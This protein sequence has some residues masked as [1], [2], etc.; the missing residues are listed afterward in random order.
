MKIN[1]FFNY[2]KTNREERQKE[3]DYCLEKNI[4]NKN[5]DNIYLI[6]SKDININN[7]KVISID[8]E[9]IPTFRYVV[10]LINKN[11][12]LEDI[13]IILNSDCYLDEEDTPMLKKIGEK[14]VW[15]LTRQTITSFD[16]FKYVLYND[17]GCSQDSWIFK[18][19]KVINNIDFEFG[20]PG[21]DNR[22]AYE[23]AS[24]G[25]NLLNPAKTFRVYHYHMSEIRTFDNSA[26]S[27]DRVNGHY[28]FIVP[29]KLETL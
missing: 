8:Y 9:E 7:D 25:L 6:K 29:K 28:T 4:E 14:E 18:G 16:P 19:K 13:N 12:G 2:Y 10:N 21:C 22:F 24:S 1:L 15:C 5:I 3:L 26:N 27:T 11:S 17:G 20:K 23:L